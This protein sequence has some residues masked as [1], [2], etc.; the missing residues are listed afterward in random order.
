MISILAPIFCAQS[1]QL[2]LFSREISDLKSVVKSMK[3]W[4]NK[5]PRILGY[6]ENGHI[7]AHTCSS[8]T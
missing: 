3:E 2:D 8:G 4:K 7:K 6:Q 5:I 1:I